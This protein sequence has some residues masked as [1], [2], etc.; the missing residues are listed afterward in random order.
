MGREARCEA[1]IGRTKTEGRLL[2]ET[3]DLVFRG[4][5]R[6]AVRL[7]SIA[8]AEVRNGW[9]E[10]AHPDGTA[11]F[12][13]GDA[14]EKWA[15]AILNPRTRIE[16]LDV[17]PDAKVAAVGFR[18]D[19]VFLA[20]LERRAAQVATRA[21]GTSYDVIFL[22]ADS[23]AA[24]GRIAALRARIVPNG[25]VWV[26]TPKGRPELGHGPVV[27]AAKAAGLV[28]VKAAR[29]SETHT[30]LKLMIPRVRR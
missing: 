6:L 8:R 25:A 14:A 17:K 27:T 24:L 13:L 2:L 4:E 18:E 11:R 28:D 16:K 23:P 9:L 5:P 22:R 7:Q 21:T 1:V 3:D 30:A 12:A 29:F 10:I 19:P 26:V 20:E 15:H